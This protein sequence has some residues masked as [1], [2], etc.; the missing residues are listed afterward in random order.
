M[1]N[2]S[3]KKI[4]KEYAGKV[5]NRG[6]SVPAIFFL[7]MFKYL[8]FLF[9]QSM[10]V[11]GPLLTLF[12]NQKKYYQFSDIISSRN[13]VEYFICQIESNKGTVK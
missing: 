6:L 3:E 1:M 12:I 2:K 5:T 8:S 13:N 9:G 7:E 10:I 4:L 11:F